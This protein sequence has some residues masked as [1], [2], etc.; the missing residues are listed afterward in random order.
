MS[1]CALRH[2]YQIDEWANRKRGKTC[3]RMELAMRLLRMWYR[4]IAVRSLSRTLF[5]HTRTSI[6]FFQSRKS[7]ACTNLPYMDHAWVTAYTYKCVWVIA[8][9]SLCMHF[10]YCHVQENSAV[11]LA[12]SLHSVR[13]WTQVHAPHTAIGKSLHTRALSTT[14]NW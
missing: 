5:S 14:E 6:D 12:T 3:S 4:S 10:Y 13:V 8:I 9:N 2:A 11:F 1:E 7:K